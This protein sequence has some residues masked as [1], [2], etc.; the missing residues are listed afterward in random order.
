MESPQSMKMLKHPLAEAFLHLKWT[1]TK[2]FFY[3]NVFVY[4]LTV[5]SV[6]TFAVT[7][8]S[9]VKDYRSAM[10]MTCLF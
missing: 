5:L 4:A 9:I 10:A 8:T 7:A 2:R 1:A 3:F 6:T